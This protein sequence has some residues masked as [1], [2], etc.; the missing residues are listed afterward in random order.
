MASLV[1]HSQR[2]HG[3]KSASG[4]YSSGGGGGSVFFFSEWTTHP[5]ASPPP[6]PRWIEIPAYLRPWKTYIA[7]LFFLLLSLVY[8]L[9]PLF[10]STSLLFLHFCC[11]L[12]F[13]SL[14]RAISSS[15]SI[16]LVLTLPRQGCW[17]VSPSPLKAHPACLASPVTPAQLPEYYEKQ[18]NLIQRCTLNVHERTC[19]WLD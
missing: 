2:L 8:S 19:C 12:Y 1:K 15:F 14:Y 3:R 17:E 6:R 7:F 4:F 5:P 16:K 10:L 9:S 18:N 13:I 11:T